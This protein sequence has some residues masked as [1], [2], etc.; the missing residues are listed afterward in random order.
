MISK[1]GLALERL[2][3]CLE[4]LVENG[5]IT[6]IKADRIKKEFIDI[7]ANSKVHDE[8]KIFKRHETRLDKFWMD[9]LNFKY[10]RSCEFFDK[11]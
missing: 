6:G 10:D 1:P 11:V 5:Q 3:S 7:Y 9:T 8:F 4:L 2:A